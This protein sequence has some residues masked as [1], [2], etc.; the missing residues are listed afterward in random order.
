MYWVSM[1]DK[2]MSGWGKAEHKTDKL[3]IECTTYEEAEI[4]EDNARHRDEMKH[5]NICSNK[6]RYNPRHYQ[7]D[8]HDKNDYSSW[9][10]K[11]Y[12]R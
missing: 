7:V 3:V 1:T 11:G 9:F 12:F 8:Y 5:I 10:K 6:P 4:V 2:C